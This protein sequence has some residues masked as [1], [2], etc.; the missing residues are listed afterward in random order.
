V[1]LCA[2]SVLILLFLG[3]LLAFAQEQPKTLGKGA[4]SGKVTDQ[5]HALVPDAKATITSASGANLVIPVDDNGSYTV[6]GLYPGTYRV[7]VSADGY[8]DKV[9]DS[10]TVTPGVALTL[11]AALKKATASTR[12]NEAGANPRKTA[13]DRT[14]SSA[15]EHR[16]PS[17]DKGAISG[18]VPS[19][20][21]ARLSC[22]TRRRC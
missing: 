1:F 5:T 13:V 15:Q 17:P 4:I 7:T 16:N 3:G 18:T 2:L 12:A 21:T 6:T 9:F 11:D 14:S 8:A 20:I 19:P 22:Q 10:V